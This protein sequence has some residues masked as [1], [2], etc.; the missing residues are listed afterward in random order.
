MN[1][2][3]SKHNVGKTDRLIRAIVGVL[4]ILGAFRGGSWV[5]GVIGAV[6]VGTAYLRFCPAYKA[7]DFTTDKGENPAAK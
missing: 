5:V 1:L 6:L 2:D 3:I 7:L 4:L